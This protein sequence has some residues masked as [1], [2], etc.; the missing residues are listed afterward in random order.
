MSIMPTQQ[1]LFEG[2]QK[3]NQSLKEENER[4]K[5]QLSNRMSE[6]GGSVSCEAHQPDIEKIRQEFNSKFTYVTHLD[7]K[8]LWDWIESKLRE[9]VRLYNVVATKQCPREKDETEI[10]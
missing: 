8:N 6:L 4:L 5:K 2:L 7:T 9:S 3:A 1:E 10:N